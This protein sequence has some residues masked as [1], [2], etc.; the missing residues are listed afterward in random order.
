MDITE[1]LSES[2]IYA[3]K[4][5]WG[6]Y[7]MQAPGAGTKHCCVPEVRYLE[8]ISEYKELRR[9]IAI[10]FWNIGAQYTVGTFM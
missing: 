1:I 2:D 3:E 7:A 8:S 4:D 5:L 10:M 6:W 9:L